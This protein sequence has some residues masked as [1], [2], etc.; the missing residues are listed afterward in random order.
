MK[1]TINHADNHKSNIGPFLWPAVILLLGL[2]LTGAA[3]HRTSIDDDEKSLAAFNLHAQ[4][5]SRD[6]KNRVEVYFGVLHSAGG[7]FAGSNSVTRTEWERF[8]SFLKPKENYPGIEG[9]GVIRYIQDGQKKEFENATKREI[10]HEN[11]QSTTS[12]N[13]EHA[14]LSGVDYTIRP[15]GAREIY[16][17]VEYFWPPLNHINLLGLDHGAYPAGLK[18]LERARD[19]GLVT[20]STGL[21]YAQ[22]NDHNPPIL[23]MLPIYRNG[24]PVTTLDDRRK[25]IWGFVYARVNVADLFQ[26]AISRSVIREIYLEVFDGVDANQEITNLEKAN[27]IYDAD[28]SDI[29]HA[30]DTSPK[31]RHHATQKVRVDGITWLFYTASRPGG[32]VEQRDGIPLLI[33]LVGGLLSIGASIIAFLRNRGKQLIHQLAY[34]DHLTCLPNRK[35]L[36]DRFQQALANAQRHG[37]GMALLFLDLDKFKPINDS[38]GHGAGDKVLK[39]VADRLASC[40]REGD[41]LSRIGGD[42]FVVLLLNIAGEE[43]ISRVAQKII[44][45]TSEPIPM[46]GL[47]MQVGC[48]IG[49]SI[50][51]KDGADYDALLKNADAAMYR[52]KENGRNNFQFHAG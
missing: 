26:D 23:F 40:L 21:P 1:F 37:T 42:E 39:T 36:Q 41:T 44:D 29:P 6:V 8:V 4:D 20:M 14:S 17:P 16:Y 12:N 22:G 15:P 18:A 45:V 33:L 38:L 24:L 2:S 51:P 50:F 48:S 7:F 43:E 11:S 46:K 19:S 27:L 32:E 13:D 31:P 5:A 49:I 47:N 52:A 30:L 34:Y 25:A 10:R 35:L 28:P 3:W 9:M